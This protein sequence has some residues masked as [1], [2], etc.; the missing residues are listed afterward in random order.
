MQGKAMLGFLP[1]IFPK[2][3][4]GPVMPTSD[5]VKW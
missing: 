4:T 1:R 2:D 5:H 3:V